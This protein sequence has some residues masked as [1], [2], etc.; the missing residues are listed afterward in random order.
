MAR[1]GVVA[2]YGMVLGLSALVLGLSLWLDFVIDYGPFSLLL[3]AIVIVGRYAG[4]GPVTLTLLLGLSGMYMFLRLPGRGNEVGPF[5]R[6]VELLLVGCSA[7]LAAVIAVRARQ[8][9]ETTEGWRRRLQTALAE[10]EAIL[11]DLEQRLRF[12]VEAGKALVGSLD[13]EATLAN[14]TRL[15]VPDLADWAGLA[16]IE[17]QRLRRA[18]T[19]SAGDGFAPLDALWALPTGHEGERYLERVA[20]TGKL[21]IH[22]TADPLC[23]AGERARALRD[24]LR[25]RGPWSVAC[26]PLTARGH[27]LGVLLLASTRAGRYGGEA[28]RALV[29]EMAGWAALVLDQ[30]R[31]FRQVQQSVQVQSDFLAS[32]AHDLGNPLAAIKMRAQL[33]RRAAARPDQFGAT[34]MVQG[35][36]EI[37]ATV[38]RMTA[39]VQE[40]LDLARLRL[41]QALELNRRPT[42]LVALARR[43]AAA[44]EQQHE[45]PGRAR[46]DTALP[47]LVGVWDPSR[48]ERLVANLVGNALKYSPEGGEVVI[49]IDRQE[50]A[51]GNWAQ[52]EVR[53]RGLG[54]PAK[55]LPL[56]FEAFHRG[57]N[58]I[59][60]IRGSGI[61]LAGVRT[62]VEQHGGTITADSREGEG[63]V[64]SV[65]L[66]LEPPA[67]GQPGHA[68]HAARDATGSAT[69]RSGDR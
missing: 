26:V 7:A 48:I 32:A 5:Q 20:R 34:A 39:M 56:V 35:L 17:N 21:E 41:G 69:S 54:I 43:V 24:Q 57:E 28:D 45:A 64:M 4:V 40:V 58:V 27:T 10:R 37:L 30:A 49:T 9:L 13:Y 66:P 14:A 15:L 63:T 6:T 62:I 29:E 51:E 50:S 60:K 23:A 25:L 61:G 44:Q 19:A 55:D 2:R 67:E 1:R 3:V 38:A 59:G 53:D 8:A 36:D 16:L 65:R 47:G 68:P 11:A 18:S 52:L 33:M 12:R 46:V 31:L 42:D 22:D